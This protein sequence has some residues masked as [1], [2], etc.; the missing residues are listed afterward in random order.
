MPVN[1][2]FSLILQ[3]IVKLEHCVSLLSKCWGY[4]KTNKT[5]CVHWST[6]SGKAELF[7]CKI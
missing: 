4:S 3:R 5:E 7:K 2:P 1:F 6:Q